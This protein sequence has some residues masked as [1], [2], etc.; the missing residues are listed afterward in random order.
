LLEWLEDRQAPA[1]GLFLQGTVFNDV[2][3]NQQFDQGD[4]PLANAMVQLFLA[5]DLVHPLATVLTGADG[6][7][8]FNTTNVPGLAANTAYDIV[9]TPPSG[10]VN[11]ALQILSEI[12]SASPI[13][14]RTI[15]VTLA[16]PSSLQVSF[17]PTAGDLGP[18]QNVT[19]TFA[20]T[21]TNTF[22]AGL[23]TLHVSSS[24]GTQT[25]N[26]LCVDLFHDLQFAPNTYTVTPEST[27]QATNG[28]SSTGLNNGNAYHAGQI[29]Y[30]FNHYVASPNAPALSAEQYAGLQLAVWKLEYDPSNS[31]ATETDFTQGNLQDTTDT[32]AVA[33]AQ[34]FITEALA[35]NSEQ[36]EFL[37][38]NNAVITSGGAQGMLAAK[39]YNFANVPAGPDVDVTKT[40]DSSTVNAGQ[41]VGFTVSITNEGVGTATGV[42]LTDALPAGVGHDIVWTLDSNPSGDFVLTG[43]TAGS[44]SLTLISGLSLAPGETIT[45]HISG[46]STFADAPSP[47]FTGTLTNTA[48]VN[49]GNESAAEQNDQ[50]SASITVNAPDVDVTKTADSST[51]SAGQAVGFTVSITNEG[52]A[53]ATG[54]TLTDALPA[55]AGHDIVW[56][57]DGN[58]SGD[59][60]LTGTTAG[61]QTLTLVSGLSLA[62]GQT[63]TAHVSGTVSAADTGTLNNT[64]TVNAG[65][66]VSGERNDQ[67]SASITVNL[68]DVDVTKSADSSTVSA[69]SAVGF[70]VSITN[71]D[72]GTATGVTLA[73]ALPAG[74]GHDIVWTLDSNP[75]GNFVLTGTTAGS[76]TLTL[77]S[78]LSL[79]PG[80]T[81]TAHISGTSTFADAPSASFTGTLSNTATVNAGNEAAAEQNDQ[82]SASI[83]VNAPDV[84]VTKSADNTAVSTGQAVGFTVSI[85][86]E[87]KATATG[88]T[89]A[90]AL[91]AGAGH[92]IVW[93]LDGNASGDFVLSGTAAGSQ[94]LTLVSGLSLAPGQTIA[95]HV[96]GTVSAADTG[97]LSNTATVNAGNEAPG[98]Q[99]DHSSASITVNGPDV[100]VTKT[101]DHTAVNAGQAVGFTVSITNEGTGTAT[102]VTLTDALPAG[103][104]H[105]IVWTLD[106]NPS[107]NFV[108]SGT[109]AGSQTLTLVSGLSLTPGQ[110]I[111]A[112][113]SGTS[114]FADAPS[115]SFTGTLS[116]T[117]TV[118]ASNESAAEQNDQ[119]SAS[120]TVNAPDVDV[121]KTADKSTVN[122][123]SAVGFTVT[124]TNE[125]KTTATG[126]T[127]SDALP[128]GAGSDIVWTLD[129]NPSGDFVLTGTTAGSQ[130]L[131]LAS[132]LS[133][134]AGQTITAHISGTTTGNDAGTLPNTA[135]V[136]AGNEA[137]GEQN[138]HSSASITV[139]GPDVDVT[140]TADKATVNAGDAV[141]F[142]VAIT[143]EGSGTAT[144][145]TLS[146]A[147]PAGAGSDIVWTLDSNP[148]GDFVLTGTAAGS[149]T[150][151]LASGL[152]LT[153][154]QTIT[155]HVSGTSAFAD[156]PSPSFT[157]SL[158]NTATVNAGNETTA[159]QNDHSSASITVNAP[160]VDVTKTADNATVN[161]GDTAGF[162]VT[163]TN[164]G[165]ATATGVTLSDPLPAGAGNDI[166]WTLNSNASGDFVLTGTT[167]GSQTLILVS[168]LSLAPGQT[169]T[170]HITAT[171]TG[172]DTGSFTNT[173]TVN[174]GNETTAEQND[175]SSATITVQ[176]NSQALARGDTATIGFWHNRNGQA[177]ITS[178]NGGSTAKNLA[179]W[180]AT[181]FQYLYGAHSSH[182]LTGKTNA[183]VAALFLQFFSVSGMKT[184][185]QILGGALAVYVTNSNL[186]GNTAAGYGFNVSSTGTGAKTYNVGSNG[187]AIG[188]T[189]NTSYTVLKLL[190]QANLDTKNGTFNA[191]AFNNI[192]DGINQTG[193]I[194]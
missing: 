125:G 83:T 128:A 105:D 163:I 49:A 144:G 26:S 37:S 149:Q 167:A 65:N 98:E 10:F 169:I 51:V 24:L 7:F 67:S 142:T 137:P 147:L 72:A 112:H 92:D 74:V 122:A 123:G 13:D 161:A 86:N 114:T 97:T 111:T 164:E 130:T 124:I 139:N 78:G 189:N 50:S 99:N 148:S 82:S 157:G 176:S 94:T 40:A 187:S 107:G 32:G 194:T 191:N 153:A 120:I 131:T 6:G 88:V 134:T 59:F 158:T 48:T 190:Q 80:Q 155:A 177:L 119:S 84:D 121:T 41:A 75:S 184:D 66:E 172:N 93:T 46:T 146:D 3:N 109:T 1:T 5:S 12:D 85:T 2:N 36:V 23:L 38:A 181:N 44:Q 11:S 18:G 55:G 39:T 101:A 70:T 162:T 17:D 69:G 103:V 9:E 132:G 68:P 115:S 168:G 166:V 25:F 171:T 141:G 79:A 126:V 135:T 180:L 186:A 4:S 20:P 185:A 100:D 150:L 71:E 118:N 54:M 174:A 138:D 183:D 30:L 192:F 57:L 77:V 188:L 89:L 81:I 140:K 165:K 95:A 104:G 173:A 154:G 21:G 156:A 76:Q 16:D 56:T 28:D 136:N 87:G 63:I 42:T 116:N 90:D 159:E 35:N 53:T 182:N 8:E 61:S 33:D 170:A 58:A 133:L 19:I 152:S 151:T 64:A 113:V 102:G 14:S 73:D 91:P 31:G 179:N 108:L 22:F 106:S 175:H 52:A 45:A 110:T 43:T 27:L 15:Q 143:N 117:A 129:S 127:L 34:A 160:D 62:P 145:V 193:D 178:L 47:T 60:V 96:S 29:A